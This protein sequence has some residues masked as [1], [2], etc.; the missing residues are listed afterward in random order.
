MKKSLKEK[1]IV[2]YPDKG[3][4]KDWNEMASKLNEK[5]YNIHISSLVEN[6]DIEN[7]SDIADVF[8]V[9]YLK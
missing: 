2:A 3:C 7:G 1:K 9:H 5:G 6:L 4:Y 8:L